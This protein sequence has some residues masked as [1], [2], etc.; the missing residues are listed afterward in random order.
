MC[1]AQ[2]WWSQN[3]W[4]WMTLLV[5]WL[6]CEDTKSNSIPIDM[7]WL[8][9]ELQWTIQQ[10][11][12]KSIHQ[13]R[14]KYVISLIVRKCCEETCEIAGKMAFMRKIVSNVNTEFTFNRFLWIVS[15]I[16]QKGQFL[17]LP[18]SEFLELYLAQL[19]S[20]DN[21]DW[22]SMNSVQVNDITRLS[23]DPRD[24]NDFH[25]RILKIWT[26]YWWFRASVHEMLIIAHL[27]SLISHH[28]RMESF[29]IDFNLVLFH[30]WGNIRSNS[31]PPR[32]LNSQF[33]GYCLKSGSLLN[34]ER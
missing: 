28:D 17:N 13:W 33:V 6:N 24:M 23:A 9:S 27:W 11:M 34:V 18:M 4:K 16:D 15:E 2:V 5:E 31:L 12:I 25:D 14:I 29:W 19:S 21:S 8:S 20:L 3:G 10:S 22:V 1:S 26:R 7:K 30:I 32:F